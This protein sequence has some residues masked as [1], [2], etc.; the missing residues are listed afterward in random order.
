MSNPQLSRRSVVAG[1][2]GVASGVPS[3]CLSQSTTDPIS[4]PSLRGGDKTDDRALVRALRTGRPIHLPGGGGAAADGAYLIGA[5]PSAENLIGGARLFG[6]GMG[7][8]ILRASPRTSYIFFCDSGSADTNQNIR[9]ISISDMTLADDVA[10]LGYAEHRH[11]AHLNGV[12]AVRFER[13]EFR[14]FRGDGLYLGSGPVAG[15]ERHNRDIQILQCRFDGVNRNNRNAIS[16][17]DGSSVTIRGCDFINCTKPGRPGETGAGDPMN[18]NSGIGNPGAIDC[19]PDANA[20]AIIRDVAIDRC[21]FS[22]GG[23]AAVALLLRPNDQVRVPHRGF[24][25]SNCI[26]ERQ[27]LGFTFFGFA[28]RGAVESDAGYA[29]GYHDNDL[30]ECDTPFIINGTRQMAMSG[31]RFADCA[32]SAELGYTDHNAECVLSDN[33]FLRVGYAKSGVNG[34]VVRSASGLGLIENRFVDCGR[35]DR[36]GGRAI[37]FRSG[38]I[39]DLRMIGNRFESPT[40]RTTYAVGVTGA[41]LDR[42]SCRAEGNIF[43]FKTNRDFG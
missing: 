9:N 28:G 20:F 43:T 7:R 30:R 25:I 31:N 24:S 41:K 35:A 33:E 27:R 10:R 29:V 2:A 12:T 6:D 21:R 22:G 39:S 1:L 17:I 11:L 34:L 40:G 4:L 38:R 23:G 14:G 37:E 32:L 16:V 15:I 18:A 3:A 36:S 13:V 26:I 42:A 8:T 19:E 5:A